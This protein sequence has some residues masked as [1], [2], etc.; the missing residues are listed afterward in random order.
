M[1]PFLKWPGGKRWFVANYAH[2][3]PS[4]YRRYVEPFLGGGSI[5]FH[6]QPTRA[7][8]GDINRELI[9]AY[10]AIRDHPEKIAALMKEHHLLHSEKHYYRLRACCPT[11]SCDRAARFLYL[12]R[13]CFNGIYRVN[14]FGKFNVPKGTKSAVFLESDDFCS[15]SSLLRHAEIRR[16]D[17]EELI[18][19]A[20]EGD[21]LFADPP[22]TVNHSNNGFIKYNEKLFSWSDQ[23][24]LA[25]A[26]A[27]A[28]D[29]GAH[30]VVTNANHR[31]VRRLY[32][33][34]GFAVKALSRFS[35]V[36]GN[37]EGRD[38]FQELLA[39]SRRDAMKRAAKGEP[40]GRRH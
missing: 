36:S 26:A 7:F 24:R 35:A 19:L 33:S 40:N 8:L 12:N 34:R 20:A 18:D 14:R 5:Y 2:L 23:I 9:Q 21:L 30:V 4:K 1:V 28:R 22:Y 25:N 15:M 10:R 13:T 27:R 31:D 37:P 32:T 3:L 16:V 6:L 11:A 39:L 17:F 29:R 38:Q